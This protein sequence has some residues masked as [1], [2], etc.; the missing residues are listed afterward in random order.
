MQGL[1]YALRAKCVATLLER[2]RVEEKLG[3]V[4]TSQ[5][6]ALN[7][8]PDLR[9]PGRELFFL[10][11]GE[12][13]NALNEGRV[14]LGNLRVDRDILAECGGHTLVV[15]K[16]TLF[17]LEPELVLFVVQKRVLALGRRRLLRR[18]VGCLRMRR[19]LVT[20]RLTLGF[21]HLWVEGVHI[22]IAAPHT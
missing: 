17:E 1:D 15:H 12:G 20:L 14:V 11:P 13:L 19:R 6:P 9:S 5:P 16:D 7:K 10:V 3:T 2:D 4:A 22:V 8:R 18:K 21:G